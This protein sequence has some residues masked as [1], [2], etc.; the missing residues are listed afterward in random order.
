MGY[1]DVAWMPFV[2]LGDLM[3]SLETISFSNKGCAP[4][5]YTS[6]HMQNVEQHVMQEDC[7]ELAV[8][9]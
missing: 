5:N 7:H 4:R 3:S 2:L 8:R 9:K 6:M 1:E